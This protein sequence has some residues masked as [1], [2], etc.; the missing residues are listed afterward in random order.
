M[1]AAP[2]ADALLQEPPRYSPPDHSTP[3]NAPG[4]NGHVRN[5][6][7]YGTAAAARPGLDER[8]PAGPRHGSSR[9]GEPGRPEPSRT[10]RAS[11]HTH[12]S[13]PDAAPERSADPGNDDDVF[14]LHIP[15][16][17]DPVSAPFASP[18]PRD[19]GQT[20]ARQEEDTSTPF[21]D[22]DETLALTR[23]RVTGP[24]P[25]FAASDTGQAT[26][27]TRSARRRTKTLDD[28]EEPSRSQARSGRRRGG[29][30][31]RGKWLW[32]GG[33]LVVAAG[34]AVAVAAFT[35]L[36]SGPTGPAHT[37]VIPARLGVFAKSTQLARQM[38]VTQLEKNILSQSS[39]QVSH[40][41]SAVYQ[42]GAAAVSGPA[43]QV[44][45]FIGGRFTGASATDSVKTFTSHFNGATLANAGHLGGAA[46]CAPAQTSTGGAAVCAWFDNDTFGE[47][48]SPNLT[49]GALANELRAIRPS[50]ELLAK[51]PSS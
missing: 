15:H 48:V 42:E 19:S 32:L 16:Q 37:L 28:P 14:R 31:G 23:A 1:Y 21:G 40:L 27:G 18:A 49:A 39:G 50:I 4:T 20:S 11:Q 44:M 43:P 36:G 5:P 26:I 25:R 30:S 33:G 22:R 6:P 12:L 34:A 29:R 10:R 17:A 7:G 3:R 45:L 41:V 8:R 35:V 9:P 2:V 13:P 46:A 51:Q 38:D 24:P 47:L